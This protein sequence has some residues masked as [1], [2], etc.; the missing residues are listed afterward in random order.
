MN[1]KSLK[2]LVSIVNKL[3]KNEIEVVKLETTCE[4]NFGFPNVDEI[5]TTLI[6]RFKEKI[7]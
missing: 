6:I 1:K 5:Y 2:Y 7:K 3:I 4:T